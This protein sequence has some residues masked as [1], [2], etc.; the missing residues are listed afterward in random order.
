MHTILAIFRPN[1]NIPCK[2][3]IR[4]FFAIQLK[5]SVQSVDAPMMNDKASWRPVGE[6]P[7]TKVS[8]ISAEACGNY[9]K[10]K[11]APQIGIV[12]SAYGQ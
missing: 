4:Q 12:N 2:S 10:D 5:P 6:T 9:E 3:K 11:S 1:E 8:T 7:T